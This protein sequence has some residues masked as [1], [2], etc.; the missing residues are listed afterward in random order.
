MSNII[1]NS[2]TYG[3]VEI[4]ID[5]DDLDKLQ[6]YKIRVRNSRG[7]LYAICRY[8][9]QEPSIQLATIIYGD[10]FIDHING[11]SLDNRKQNLRKSNYT[12]N[13]KNAK[14][15]KDY[16]DSK[17][18]GV[19]RCD[20]R[21]MARIQCNK[22]RIVIGY[23]DTEIEAAKGYDKKAKELHGEFAWLNFS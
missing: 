17:Y 16:K 21:W 3:N 5:N 2:K 23:Y 13:N 11:N 7:K 20:K 4:L 18:K 22:V 8:K 12:S 15:R 10:N 1:I 6:N 19:R 9:G 14:K